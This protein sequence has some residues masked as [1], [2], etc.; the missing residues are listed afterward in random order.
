MPT[1]STASVPYKNIK[2]LMAVL[3]LKK[4]FTGDLK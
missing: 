1:E 2:L 4:T 3:G